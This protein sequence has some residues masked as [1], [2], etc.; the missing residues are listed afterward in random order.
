VPPVLRTANVEALAQQTRDLMALAERDLDKVDEDD[1]SRAA[2]E[3]YETAKR[4]LR[5]AGEALLVKNYVYARQ[6]A[7]NAATLAAQLLKSRDFLVNTAA[8]A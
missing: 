3:Q 2:R 7:D 5:L 1:L 6:L 8:T 4:F